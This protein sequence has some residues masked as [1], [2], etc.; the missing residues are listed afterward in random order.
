[1]PLIYRQDVKLNWTA[2]DYCIVTVPYGPTDKTLGSYDI[3]ASSS[4]GT[5]H[6]TSSR[7]TVARY[8]AGA[9]DM[10]QTIGVNG[11]DVD[12]CDVVVPAC[13]I[14]VSFRHP[15]GIITMPRVKQ[16]ARNTAY[17]NDDIFLTFDPGEALFLG[18][19][20]QWGPNTETAIRYEYAMAE[21]ADGAKK[22]TIGDIANIVK[23]GHDYCW[24]RYADDEAGGLPVKVAKHVYI[25]RVYARTAFVPLFGFG[26]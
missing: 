25:E 1:M 9:P 23:Q 7:S 19:D 11:N 15:Q 5:V 14:T 20:G 16:L 17:V 26:G 24:I 21:N 12:G 3:H 22:L 4:G 8:G 13:K 18:F 6:I 2:A 10:E